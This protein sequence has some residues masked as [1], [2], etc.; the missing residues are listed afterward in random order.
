MFLF[1]YFLCKPTINKIQSSIAKINLFVY[2]MFNYV[3]ILFKGDVVKCEITPIE[4]AINAVNGN[5]SQLARLVGCSPSNITNIVARG[6]RIPYR[7]KDNRDRWVAA[8]GLSKEI[9]FPDIY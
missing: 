1:L 3:N 9:L 7:S 8:T 6:G 2:I 5:K 4:K